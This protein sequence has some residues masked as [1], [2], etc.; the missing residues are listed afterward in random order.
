MELIEPGS[1]I[2]EGDPATC[3]YVLIEG[4]VVTSRQVGGDDVEIGRTSQRGRLRAAPARPT[5]ATGA[6]GLPATRCGP[7]RRPGSSCSAR[8]ASPRSCASGSRWRCTCSRACS[9]AASGP[10]QAVGQRERLLALGSLT[11]G[12]THELN[13]PAAAAVRATRACASGSRGCAA[14]SRLLAAGQV[15]P[16]RPGDPHRA[17]AARGGDRSPRRPSS[18]RWTRPTA[19]T[20]SA[21]GSRTTACRDGWQL[22]PDVRPGRPRRRVARAGA[23]M[24]RRRRCSSPRCAG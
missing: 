6:A 24:R 3:F 11:A 21:T 13:N 10:A 1:S 19:R 8:T 17:A 5:W 23:D 4:T 2:A 14:S 7:P 9:S 18:T 12:L 22:A 15:R 16:G 20:S